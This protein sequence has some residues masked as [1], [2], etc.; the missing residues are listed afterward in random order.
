MRRV[1]RTSACSSRMR[2][3]A[4]AVL[5]SSVIFAVAVR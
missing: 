2:R 1:M 4:E 5:P 3:E